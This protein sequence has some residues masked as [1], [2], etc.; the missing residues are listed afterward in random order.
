MPRT[1]E[2][3]VDAHRAARELRRQGKPIW[4]LE[5]PLKDILARYRAAGDDLSA[6]QALAL[7][8]EVAGMLKARVPAAWLKSDH[9][10]FHYGYEELFENLDQ[11][12]LSDFVP[13]REDDRSPCDVINGYLEEL[14]DW[15]DRC[16]VWM[17]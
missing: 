8:T 9:A 11:A 2:S 16:R 13:T 10:K 1:V 12:S 17:K 15:G 6:E 5:L 7:C 3:I 4:A 14:Y